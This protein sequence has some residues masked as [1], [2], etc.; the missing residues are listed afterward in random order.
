MTLPDLVLPSRINQRWW[1][2][3]IDDPDWCM[4][5]DRWHRYDHEIQYIYNSRG[6]RDAEWPKD[7]VN[8]TWC[9]G[10]SFTVGI[11]VPLERTWPQLLQQQTQRRCINV[12]MDGASNDW[13]ARRACQILQAVQPRLIIIHWTYTHRREIADDQVL[14]NQRWQ[15]FYRDI[16]D[17]TWPDCETFDQFTQLPRAI[18][19]EIQKDPYWAV[20]SIADDHDRRL[21]QPEKAAVLDDTLN[22]PVFF[23]AVDRVEQCRGDTQILHTFIPAFTANSD[24]MR[25]QLERHMQGLLWI[26]EVEQLDWARDGHHYDVKTAQVL[27]N[28]ICKILTDNHINIG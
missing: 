24:R 22:D 15:A 20:I 25:Q 27:V 3:G 5:P 28:N 7:L 14:L 12:S 19:Q 2:Q 26:P 16:R 11:G 9:I 8:A 18:Q 10:D 23:A 6:F 17:A 1:R 21:D 13:M 4:A